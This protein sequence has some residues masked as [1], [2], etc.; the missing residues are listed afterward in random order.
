MQSPY[1]NLQPVEEVGISN[2]EYFS[3]YEYSAEPGDEDAF[4][5]SRDVIDE[6]ELALMTDGI[7]SAPRIQSLAR[8]GEFDATYFESSTVSPSVGSE[9]SFDD[10]ENIKTVRFSPE[11][12]EKETYPGIRAGAICKRNDSLRNKQRNG[13]VIFS[14]TS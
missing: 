4:P 14:Q 7:E 2:D 10:A 9:S 3:M 6:N 5:F 8:L 1:A 11:S 12:F 13:T